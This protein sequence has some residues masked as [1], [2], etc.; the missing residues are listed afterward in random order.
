MEVSCFQLKEDSNFGFRSFPLT[1]DKWK[2]FH[3]MHKLDP[4]QILGRKMK[5][6]RS[7]KQVYEKFK[8]QVEA[9]QWGGHGDEDI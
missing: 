6:V 7:L 1:G 4:A 3:H 2:W 8:I 9:I 5:S